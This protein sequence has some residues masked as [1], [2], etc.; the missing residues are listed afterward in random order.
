MMLTM[1]AQA[2]A[3]G[4]RHEAL[5]RTGLA[6]S[7]HARAGRRT[8]MLHGIQRADMA[9]QQARTVLREEIALE[10]FDDRLQVDH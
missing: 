5:L 9:G 6:L 10:C 4:M 3:T 8:A 7:L 1:R 2:M